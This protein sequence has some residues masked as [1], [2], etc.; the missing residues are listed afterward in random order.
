MQPAFGFQFWS[1]DFGGPYD[2]QGNGTIISATDEAAAATLIQNWCYSIGNDVYFY[3][4]LP[5]AEGVLKQIFSQTWGGVVDPDFVKEMG[6]W[7]G[8]FAAGWSN[9]Y[10]WKPT[11]TRSELDSYKDP[12]IYGAAHGSKY[13]SF[14]R[15]I[16]GTGPYLFTSWDTVNKI[17][18]IDYYPAYWLGFGQAGDKAGNY[19]KTVIEKGIDSYPT[20]KMLF[21]EGEFDV[22]AIPR[23][24]MYDLLTSTYNP[25]AGV[26]LVYNVANL[27]NEVMLFGFNISTASP[28]QC[29]VGYPTHQTGPEAYFFNNTHLRRAFS[30]ALNYTS[31]FHDALFDEAILQRSWWVDGLS[32][33]S[34][35]NTNSS[36]PQ[37]NL[38]LT[39]MQNELNLAVLDGINVG[40]AGFEMTLVYNIGN[41]ARLIACNLI[42]QAFL[43]LG[44]KYKVN[45]VGLDW[46]VMLD[47]ENSGYLPMY[48]IGW[49][50]DFAD[51][52]N[53]CEPYQK[54]TGAFLVGQGPPFPED[55]DL[56]DTEI[57][58]A[59]IQPNFAIRGNM[60][61]DLQYRY[62]LDSP[63]FTLY[64]PV[65]RRFAR[66]WVQGWY[67]N[68]L[69]PGL[70]AYDLYKSTTTL[71]NVDV[72]MTGT[73]TP[74]TPTYNPV[75]VFHNQM[76]K[77][78]ND[79]S[80]ASMTY[81]LHVKR[82]DSNAAIT[83]LYAAVGLAR[84]NSTDKQFANGTFVALLAGGDASVT[85]TWWEDGVNQK[86]WGNTTG[87]P[88][89]VTG[90]TAVMN[91]NAQDSNT[92]NNVQ[93]AGTLIAKTLDGD[94]TGN[95]IVD[96]F[97]AIQ[98]AGAFGTKSGD[99]K[100]N[101]DADINLD[102]LVDILDA[103][104]LAGSFN[105][106]VP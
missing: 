73:V 41:D 55:Q 23:P 34:Y 18:R 75:Y 98:L 77:G 100:W 60:Y 25:I 33:A 62:W 78:N 13:A 26:N 92:V 89:A 105:K 72:D 68:A 9:N 54:S 90:E 16:V 83:T 51:P 30:W 86:M 11:A 96:I 8:S 67:Y 52:D 17:W 56:V 64:Q 10:L 48:D 47:A 61:K 20:R 5:W 40:A 27:A 57:D 39:Q 99:K 31:Y 63:S 19:F 102:G 35:K 24:N 91:A 59:M 7:D 58:N 49:L 95:G 42:A 76:R 79:A 88:Y 65:G 97:D 70:F 14:V 15:R 38:D 1:S 37:R 21:L 74:T 28:Y 103:I 6:G 50:A 46:P 101:A 85:L 84:A 69:Y 82:T 2:C 4:K 53:F 87:L 94:I 36:M 3:F 22:A 29:Y 104:K 32:P 93:A 66:D 71:Q 43:S 12:A 81:T 80:A 45:V 44:S 106:H